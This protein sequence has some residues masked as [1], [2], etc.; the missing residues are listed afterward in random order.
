M[1][2]KNVFLIIISMLIM[3]ILV[4]C[5]K[6]PKKVNLT[7]TQN[8]IQGLEEYMPASELTSSFSNKIFYEVEDIKWDGN[9][10]LASVTVTTPNLEIII[11]DSINSAT[12][13]CGTDDYNELLNQ[14]KSNI[15]ETLESDN[16]P[17]INQE[18][19]M[20]AEKH[21]DDYNLISNEAFEKIIQGNVEDIFLNA[22]TGRE[23]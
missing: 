5:Q 3:L 13:S 1:K 18:V 23:Q 15:Q 4:S 22:L 9:S 20:K 7:E 14:V 11:R 6:E 10:G 19:E 12:E 8:N 16:C 21:D 2:R 17:M